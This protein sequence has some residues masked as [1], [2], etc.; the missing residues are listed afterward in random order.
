MTMFPVVNAMK[1][2]LEGEEVLPLGKQI[3]SFGQT[4]RNYRLTW[5]TTKSH[6]LLRSINLHEERHAFIKRYCFAVPTFEAITLLGKASPLIEIGAGSGAW[7]RLMC[8]RG[9]DVIATDPG[10]ESFHFKIGEWHPVVDLQ[11]KTAVRRWPDRNVF[12]SWPSLCHTWLRQA[13]RAMRPGR[14]LIVVREDATADERTWDY[15]EDAFHLVEVQELLT[16][17][18]CHDQLEVWVKQPTH[19]RTST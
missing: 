16:F 15:I 13:A 5:S 7:T 6:D 4:Y 2:W 10:L 8:N 11:G 14:K 9:I 1:A 17:G 19:R 3:D 18:T 12:C